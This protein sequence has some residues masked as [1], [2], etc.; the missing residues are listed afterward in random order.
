MLPCL[1]GASIIYEFLQISTDIFISSGCLFLIWLPWVCL[2]SLQQDENI[3]QIQL[4]GITKQEFY[5]RVQISYYYVFLGR[6][7]RV[8]RK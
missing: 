3:G 2:S 7:F 5:C 8:E 6:G 4:F 1:L